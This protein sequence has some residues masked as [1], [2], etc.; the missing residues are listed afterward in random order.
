MSSKKKWADLGDGIEG[1][2]N[3]DD[4]QVCVRL[5]TEINNPMYAPLVVSKEA[6]LALLRLFPMRKAD[7]EEF[8]RRG[9]PPA[10]RALTDQEIEDMSRRI[11]LDSVG[12]ASRLLVEVKR[13]RK[14]A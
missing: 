11:A 10:D 12:A 8:V 1:W 2:F 3:D 5:R 13:L 7:A 6:A 14:P 4:E 9:L